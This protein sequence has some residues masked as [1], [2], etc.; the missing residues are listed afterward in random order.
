MSWVKPIHQ[1]LL[2]PAAPI[3][4][5]PHFIED[6]PVYSVRCVL[7]SLTGGRGLSYLVSWEWVWPR[8]EVLVSVCNILDLSEDFEWQNLEQAAKM[9]TDPGA[10]S[11]SPSP[12]EVEF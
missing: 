3:P 6:G 2:V 10:S 8:E 11:S 1:S 9:P 4:P 5:P 12:S 7:C